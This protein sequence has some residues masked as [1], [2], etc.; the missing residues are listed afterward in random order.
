M[1]S[2]DA[3]TPPLPLTQQEWRDIAYMVGYYAED[4]DGVETPDH[5]RR[6]LLAARVMAAT[7]GE[8]GV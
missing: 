2:N 8:D 6:R 7:S 3:P 4:M 1:T 5:D